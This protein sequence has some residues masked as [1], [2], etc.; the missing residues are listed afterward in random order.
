MDGSSED[1][2]KKEPWKQRN[3]FEKACASSEGPSLLA[4]FALRTLH[5]QRLRIPR[6]VAGCLADAST[7]G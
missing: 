4:V 6:V 2:V 3:P 7:V 5:A 1:A